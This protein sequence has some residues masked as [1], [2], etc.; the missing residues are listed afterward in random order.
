[1]WRANSY[2]VLTT[3]IKCDPPQVEND[4]WPDISWYQP[5]WRLPPP[6]Q[7][8]RKYT[9]M[10]NL[11]KYDTQS[12]HRIIY[13]LIFWETDGGCGWPDWVTNCCPSWPELSRHVLS[14]VMWAVLA[15]VIIIN[16]TQ[17]HHFLTSNSDL[18]P[19]DARTKNNF[20]RSTSDICGRD[21]IRPL[22]VIWAF[23]DRSNMSFQTR[24]YMIQLR[25]K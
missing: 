4:K 7:Y 11:S 22:G 19:L 5:L 16:T 14:K 8:L 20:D 18:N 6:A 9:K 17:C 12:V 13:H 25:R 2:P 24:N 10:T 3:P 21:L 23:T 1:M 15:S